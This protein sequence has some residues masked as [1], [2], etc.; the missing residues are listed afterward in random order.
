VALETEV[1]GLLLLGDV[2]DRA[3]TL[4]TANR[5]AGSV[6]EGTD[7]ACLPFQRRLDGLEEGAGVLEVD[8][9]DPAFCSS[10]NEKIGVVR[11][12]VVSDV[13]AVYAILAGD[14][15]HG[16]LLAKIPIFHSLVPAASDEHVLA[17]DEYAFDTLDRF[18]VRRDLLSGCAAGTEVKHA[19]SLVRSSAK[20]LLTILGP[21][22]REHWALVLEHGLALTLS[23][24]VD[25]VDA[26]LLVPAG[27]CKVVALG[28]EAHVGDAVLGRVGQRY[29]FAEVA[30]CR[31]CAGSRGPGAEETCHVDGA[32]GV[33]G[34]ARRVWGGAWTSRGIARCL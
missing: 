22:A 7:C 28:R 34:G 31:V 14:G 24:R 19:R 10:N 1:V 32:K 13:H 33:G 8:D 23:L 16:R 15:G 30:L 9:I 4:N 26:D 18:I 27:N 20:D 29:I 3:A 25:L 2:L 5:I 6:V 21:T 17:V 12:R 11:G